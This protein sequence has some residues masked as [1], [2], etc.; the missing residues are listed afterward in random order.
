MKSKGNEE[1]GTREELLYGGQSREQEPIPQVD[2]STLTDEEVNRQLLSGVQRDMMEGFANISVSSEQ[3]QN[4]LDSLLNQ[5]LSTASVIRKIGKQIDTSRMEQERNR[6]QQ[7]MQHRELQSGQQIILASVS[8][9]S[10][11]LES[12]SIKA[13]TLLNLPF[14]Q[15]SSRIQTNILQGLKHS[16]LSAVLLPITAP[17]SIIRSYVSLGIGGLKLVG[18]PFNKLLMIWCAVTLV[19][20][21]MYFLFHPEVINIDNSHIEAYNYIRNGV[22]DT[23]TDLNRLPY[24]KKV[25]LLVKS[26]VKLAY[27]PAFF[28]FNTVINIEKPLIGYYDFTMAAMES[29]WV[30]DKYNDYRF[31][32]DNTKYRICT[33]NPLATCIKPGKPLTFEEIDGQREDLILAEQKRETESKKTIETYTDC[34]KRSSFSITCGIKPVKFDGTILADLIEGRRREYLL[35]DVLGAMWKPAINFWE[36]MDSYPEEI[37]QTPPKHHINLQ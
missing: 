14:N 21:V 32:Y 25:G 3:Q 33:L 13:S 24:S 20:N 6:Q 31:M 29:A 4:Q 18:S 27:K 5:G 7:L 30:Y 11:M 2:A 22:T 16:A 19:G 34:V 9:T 12:Q 36:N 8:K 15:W 10:D 23:W 35:K 1:K 17:L 28:T 26:S 37:P